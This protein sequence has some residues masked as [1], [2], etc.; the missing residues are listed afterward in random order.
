MTR[1]YTHL[2]DPPGED[3]EDFGDFDEYDEYDEYDDEPDEDTRWRWVAG[4]ATAVLV[5]AVAGTVVLLTGGDN[6]TAARVSP[7]AA[8]PAVTTAT[9]SPP[10]PPPLPSMPSET[11]TTVPPPAP[12][13]S[14]A[15]PPSSEA[16]PTN[17]APPPSS[18]AAPAPEAAPARRTVVYIVS[19]IRRRG[20]FVTVTYSD[21]QGTI[22]TDL[23]VVLPWSRTFVMNPDVAIN[24]VSATSFASQLNCTI[25]DGLGGTIAAQQNNAIAATCNR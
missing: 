7:P 9:Q 13:S 10:A 17:E 2:S 11:V 21:E 23:N 12:P 14:E 8:P 6:G 22:H 15:P 3:F 5:A 19:G 25:S 24:T 18:A 20:D 1:S 16:A 4:V